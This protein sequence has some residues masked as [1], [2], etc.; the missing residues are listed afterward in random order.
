MA[1]YLENQDELH[2]KRIEELE[3]L[4]AEAL[5]STTCAMAV[6][7]TIDILESF[8]SDSAGLP[9]TAEVRAKDSIVLNSKDIDGFASYTF[10][11]VSYISI[12][13][14]DGASTSGV[15]EV[16]VINENMLHSELSSINLATDTVKIEWNGSSEWTMT[17]TPVY[18][19]K[20][21]S[22]VPTYVMRNYN[23]VWKAVLS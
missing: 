14:S 16:L 18:I 6:H 7:R 8:R 5:K 15:G 2:K 3:K 12:T 17:I 11:G 19:E 21:V 13:F 23:G 20:D 9:N 4:R 10:A 1:R 22:G